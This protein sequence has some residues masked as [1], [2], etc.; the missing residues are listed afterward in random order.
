MT[1]IGLAPFTPVA[2]GAGLTDRN[3]TAAFLA[4]RPMAECPPAGDPLVHPVM[5]RAVRLDAKIAVIRPMGVRVRD[6]LPKAVPR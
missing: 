1:V 2:P 6:T 4:A 5:R 3:L